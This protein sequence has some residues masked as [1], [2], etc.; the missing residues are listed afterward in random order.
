MVFNFVTIF[1]VI[2]DVGLSSSILRFL[3]QAIRDGKEEEGRKIVKISFLFTLM[4]SGIIGMGLALFSSPLASVLLGKQNLAISLGIASFSVIGICLSVLFTS[5]LQAKQK[6]VF[7]VIADSSI[8]F[9]KF[10]GTILLLY[11]SQLTVVSVFIVYSLTSFSGFIIGFFLTG[12][13]F[14]SSHPNRLLVKNLLSFGLWV[15]LAR[16]ANGIAGRLDTL[17]LIH[18]VEPDKVGFYAAAQKMTFIFPVLINGL[19][20]VINPAFSSFKS[21]FE[22]SKFAKK[23]FFLV[24]GL[25]VLVGVLFVSAPY[26]VVKIFGQV[27]AP[28][29]D[30]L[31]WL[32]VSIFF[33]IASSV[34]MTTLIYFLGESKVFALISFVQLLIVYFMNYLLIPKFGVIAPAIS[35]AFAY[36]VLFIISTWLVYTRLKK[37]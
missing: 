31:R 34:P 26:L 7:G 13:G 3:P 6:F 25:F 27:Y 19:M 35:L 2:C 36:G 23:A 11:F 29:A 18:Y 12:A 30:I 22:A 1:Y 10:I 37:K 15:A 33:S 28:A 20:V 32:L 21:N 16:I 8:I 4:V 14:L 9:L 24:S 17:M 5:I